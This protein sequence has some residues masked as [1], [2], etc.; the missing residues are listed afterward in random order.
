MGDRLR[1]GKPSRHVTATEVDSACYPPWDGKMSIS[2]RAV[3]MIIND[4][5]GC[6][7]LAAFI[8]GPA[9]QAGWLC[10]KGRRPPGAVSVFIA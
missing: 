6:G 10:P 8:G 1:A 3:V 5:G 2:F 4:D 7:L 9:A